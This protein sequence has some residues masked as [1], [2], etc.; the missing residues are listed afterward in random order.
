MT[1]Q[2]LIK[3]LYESEKVSNKDIQEYILPLLTPSNVR[4]LLKKLECY[5]NFLEYDYLRDKESSILLIDF[6][7]LAAVFDMINW[8]IHKG[9]EIPLIAW[10]REIA[11]YLTETP[12]TLKS[13]N[14]INITNN[15]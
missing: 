14:N 13:I 11:D 1:K 10:K 5:A 12:E 9:S 15:D 6:G 2:E 8:A 4:L 3:K 7:K